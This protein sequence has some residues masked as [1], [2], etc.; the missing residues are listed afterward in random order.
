MAVMVCWAAWIEDLNLD[1]I[2][3]NSSKYG[4][5]KIPLTLMGLPIGRTVAKVSALHVGRPRVA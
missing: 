4:S 1:E 5:E 2:Q 3:P